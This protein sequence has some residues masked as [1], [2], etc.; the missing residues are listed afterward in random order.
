MIVC[1]NAFFFAAE[2]RKQSVSVS[3]TAIFLPVSDHFRKPRLLFT[4]TSLGNR[5]GMG[6]VVCLTTE[7]RP[8][9]D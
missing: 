7:L 2:N 3:F 1:V 4:V 9:S 5:K 8:N 6:F